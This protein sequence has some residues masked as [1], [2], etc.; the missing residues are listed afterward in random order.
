MSDMDTAKSEIIKAFILK[1]Y[2]DGPPEEL[3]NEVPLI[4]SGII[5]SVS[6]LKVVVFLESNFGFEF[7]SHEIDEEYLDTINLMLELIHDKSK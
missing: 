1:H 4:S 6:I 3:T 5:D 2:F 7:E